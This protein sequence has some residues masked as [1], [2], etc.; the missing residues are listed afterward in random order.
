MHIFLV[1]F[2]PKMMPVS[3]SLSLGNIYCDLDEK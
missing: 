1:V 2:G 3:V